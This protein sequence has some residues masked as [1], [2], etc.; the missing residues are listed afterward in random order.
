M[1]A[2]PARLLHMCGLGPGAH[3]VHQG[4][5]L[6]V[7]LLGELPPPDLSV[8]NFIPEEKPHFRIVL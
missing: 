6:C 4:G 2:E 3:Q 1:S 5:S 8:G 7:I